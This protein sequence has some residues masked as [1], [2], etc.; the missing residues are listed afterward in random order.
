MTPARAIVKNSSIR[1]RK[2][3]SKAS[4]CR[5]FQP[6]SPCIR[7][8]S[9]P[10]PPKGQVGQIWV[11]YL[12]NDFSGLIGGGGRTRTFEAMRRLIYSQLL[13]PLRT[14]P[15]LNPIASSAAVDSGNQPVDDA[16]SRKAFIK[17][18]SR[19]VYGRR[20]IAKST[21]ANG[22]YANNFIADSRI[23]QIA[24]GRNP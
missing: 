24:L 17:A 8:P 10:H 5:I 3:Q 4:R 7:A 16:E 11:F 6:A 12:S 9:A 21:D 18:S 14:L 15:H 23:R 20:A 19:R 2:I 13:L 1:C 22:K